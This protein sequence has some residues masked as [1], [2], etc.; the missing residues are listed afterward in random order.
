MLPV[1]STGACHGPGTGR[2]AGADPY[3]HSSMEEISKSLR[4]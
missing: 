4:T 1:G 3:H 2:D